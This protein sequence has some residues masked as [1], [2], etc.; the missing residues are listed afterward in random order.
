VSPAGF[1]LK[2]RQG[3]RSPDLVGLPSVREPSQPVITETLQPT[4]THAN[5]KVREIEGREENTRERE[6][7]EKE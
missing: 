7:E 5:T 3:D 2:G 4:D 1:D 6:R